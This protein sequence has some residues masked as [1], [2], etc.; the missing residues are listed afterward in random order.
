MGRGLAGILADLGAAH[1]SFFGPS[2]DL[3]LAALEVFPKRCPQPFGARSI[4]LPIA[5]LAAV[6]PLRAARHALS[7]GRGQAFIKP[8]PDGSTSA[9]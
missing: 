6:P 1:G 7:I 5:G 3:Q 9:Q 8:Q 2:F 4:T